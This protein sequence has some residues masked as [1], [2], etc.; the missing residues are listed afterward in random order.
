MVY[1]VYRWSVQR[2]RVSEH[3]A[4]LVKLGEHIKDEHPLIQ[5]VR[6]WKVSFGSDVGRPG[7]VWAELFKTLADYEE[8]G[9]TEYTAACDEAWAPIF[10][11]MVPGSMTSS[12]WDEVALDA[13]FDRA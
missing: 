13:W 8:H 4:A 11:A 3:D 6:S 7:R 5:G 2:E 12:I 9:R 1:C 10:E